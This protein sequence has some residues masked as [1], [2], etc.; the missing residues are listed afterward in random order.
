[1][2]KVDML[3]SR[4][5]ELTRNKGGNCG[6]NC[7]KLQDGILLEREEDI[8]SRWKEYVEELYD[9]DGRPTIDEIKI[10]EEEDVQVDEMGPEL[11][12]EEIE[13]AVMDLKEK[14]AEGIDGIP[15]EFWRNVGTGAMREIVS[16]C[17]EISEQEF[18]HRILLGQ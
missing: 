10:E 18:G 2:N 8:M 4:I 14:K 16:L 12:E 6:T 15:A 7:V 17:K 11:M 13:A 1:M 3:Y 9:K 5:K